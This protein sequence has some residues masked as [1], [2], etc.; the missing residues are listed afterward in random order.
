MRRICAAIAI[1]VGAMLLVLP[2]ALS[3]FTRTAASQR[4]T[5]TIRPAMAGP[6]LGKLRGDFDTGRD[7][8]VQLIDGALPALAQRLGETPDQLNASIQAKYPDV[9]DGF[10]Q[11]PGIAT[12]VDGVLTLFEKDKGEFYAADAI[13]TT[14]LPFT[15]GPWAMFGF[16]LVLVAG[17]VL[18][19]SSTSPWTIV[20]IAAAGL[21]LVIGP[22]VVSFP[23]KTSQAASLVDDLRPLITRP[24]ADAVKGWQSAMEKMTAQLQGQMLPDLATQL[25]T[26]PAELLASLQPEFP[27]VATGL[28]RLN[29]VFVDFADKTRRL[30]ASVSDF[31]QTKQIP[32]RALPWLFIVP[33]LVLAA[34]AGVAL[35]TPPRAPAPGDDELPTPARTER[36]RGDR[37]RAGRG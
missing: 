32:F 4:L 9:A 30:D 10:R 29:Q 11:F 25:G 19:W 13:P 37:V 24:T 7:A 14:W 34:G 5:D 3:L 16:G 2:L 17:G 36:T 26:T 12:K 21:T 15:V 8:G 18:A 1:G 23:H 28:P 6:A 22:L 20:A 27:A 31:G 33:G 35:A